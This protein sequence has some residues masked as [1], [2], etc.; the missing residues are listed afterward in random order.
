VTRAHGLEGVVAK[1]LDSLYKPGVR[2]RLWL[3]TK[4]YRIGR[5][6]IGGVVFTGERGTVLVGVPAPDGRLHYAGAVEVFSRLQLAGILELLR[7]RPG[8][9]FHEWSPPALFVEPDVAVEIRY[10]A[11]EPSGLRH[12]TLVGLCPVG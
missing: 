4:N 8:S 10:L 2:S 3:K 6:L 9:P 12:A 1:R 7:A 11:L 5:F